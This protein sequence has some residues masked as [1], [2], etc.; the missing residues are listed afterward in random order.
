M[1]GMEIYTVSL[2]GHREINQPIMVAE[3]LEK[4]IRKL[5]SGKEYINFLIGRDGEFD[6][7]TAS[8]IRRIIKE[9]DYGN[10]S[11][12]LVLPYMKAEYR[13]NEQEYL[14]YY[15]EVEICSQ[16]SKAHFK[17]AI[18]I[19]N[20]SM[21]DRSELVIFFVEHKKGGAYQSLRYAKQSG[22]RTINIA[23]Y[24]NK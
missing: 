15:D 4:I 2:F 19:R 8:V 22:V 9:L 13:D 10:A 24:V 12:T 23:E 17:A 1:I 16:S 6:I 18:Q 7:I 11:L 5:I 21:I 3:K 14:T 20:K